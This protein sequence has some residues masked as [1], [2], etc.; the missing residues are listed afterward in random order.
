VIV[1]L[2]GEYLDERAACISVRDPGFLYADGVFETALL[3]NGGFLH[4]AH[5]LDRFAESAA[6]LR[7]AAPGTAAIDRIVREVV[8]R[9]GLVNASIRVTL[10]RGLR[11]PTLLV[12]ATHPDQDARERA[13]RGW[14]VITARTRR[15]AVSAVPAQL[16]MLG[17]PYALLARHEALAAGADDALLL[18]DRDLICEGP[19]WNIFWR[20]GDTLMTPHTDLGVLAGVT[21]ATIIDIARADGL[22]VHEGSWPRST[23]DQADEIFATMT[24]LGLVS[25][26]SLDGRT[27]PAETPA[28]N[29]LRERYADH[30]NA[31]VAL[32]P[33]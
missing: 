30:V 28:T 6:L 5:H 1:Y 12:T 10:T 31:A 15:P 14:H 16:K 18:T 17:R 23:L 25:F 9:N 3:Q 8:R 4:L 33:L 26:R 7:L 11:N 22:A 2:N 32:D 20:T 24:S 13:R 27:L 21:R 19:T 29:T